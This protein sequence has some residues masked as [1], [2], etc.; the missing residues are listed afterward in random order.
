MGRQIITAIMGIL[1]GFA[2][3]FGGA[4]ALTAVADWLEPYICTV[5]NAVA[6]RLVRGYRRVR[7]V[8]D[9]VQR[10]WRG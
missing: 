8:S 2:S 9:Q 1:A 7:R 10:W 4:F 5:L 3:V 6:L